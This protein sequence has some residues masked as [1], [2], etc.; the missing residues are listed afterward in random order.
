METKKALD[1]I[2]QQIFNEC[3]AD[4]EPVTMEEAREMA[5]MELKAKG[6]HRYEQAEKPPGQEKKK[7]EVKLDEAKVDF[8]KQLKNL[9]DGMT[10][11]SEIAVANPQKEITFIMGG[12]AYSLNLVKHRPPKK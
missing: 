3:A 4:G 7:R 5:E 9:L 6:V 2:T 12:D 8:L 11:L 10:D 1:K